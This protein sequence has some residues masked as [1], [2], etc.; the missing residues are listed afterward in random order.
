M[1]KQSDVLH[2]CCDGDNWIR[3]ALCKTEPYIYEEV[4]K[5][6]ATKLL[7]KI[8]LDADAIEKPLHLAAAFDLLVAAE[9]YRT[10]ASEGWGHCL[11]K[12]CSLLFYPYVN[13]CPRCL[14]QGQFVFHKANKPKS[15]SI[16]LATSKLLALFLQKL[17]HKKG[18][19]IEVVKGNEPVD[20]VFRDNSS[21]S[22]VVFFAEIKAAPLFTLPLAI[23]DQRSATAVEHSMETTQHEE[24]YC[25]GLYDSEIGI[26]LPYKKDEVTWGGQ[27][28]P[29]G[30]KVDQEDEAWAYNGLINLLDSDPSFIEGYFEFW[31]EAFECYGSRLKKNPYWFTNAC[32]G[33]DPRPITWPKRKGTGYETISD[34]KTSVGMDRT[35]DLKKAIYQVLKIGTAGK[36]TC[37]FKYKVGIVTNIPAVRHHGEYI[38]PVK[39]IIWARDESASAQYVGDLAK[40]KGLFN[41]FDGIVSLTEVSARDEWIKATFTF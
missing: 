27:I 36:P 41:L 21:G 39:D 20:L 10:V 29:L 8:Y 17:L 1:L 38:E 4:E 37:T 3:E 18:S 25:T 32:G 33:P 11:D 19:P 6:L 2:S 40:D 12:G 14:L 23:K 31:K 26:Y 34:G 30:K 15:G 35:D 7:D 9:Y 16:G 13:A 28:F 5:S 22:E 24:I